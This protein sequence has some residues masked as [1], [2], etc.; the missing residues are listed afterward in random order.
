MNWFRLTCKVLTL[1]LVLDTKA[2]ANSGLYGSYLI[3]VRPVKV[4]MAPGSTDTPTQRLRKSSERS[5]SGLHSYLSREM[6]AS[7]TI[8]T[9]GPGSSISKKVSSYQSFWMAPV[10]KISCRH[11]FLDELR[12]H[13]DV[14]EIV[15][16]EPVY[17][18]VPVVEPVSE[19]VRLPVL[20]AGN[21]YGKGRGIRIGV[22]DSGIVAHPVFGN[23]IRAY[24]DFTSKPLEAMTDTAGHGTFVASLVAGGEYQG[25]SLSFA[26]EADLIVARALETV[27]AGGTSGEVSERVLAFASRILEAMQWILDPDDN[28]STPDHPHIMINSWGFTDRMPIA[29]TF[30]DDAILAW[31]DAGIIVLFAAG[32]E[33]RNGADTIRYPG[34]SSEVLTIG[35]VNHVH[36]VSRFSSLGGASQQKPDFVYYGENRDGLGRFSGRM[37]LGKMSGTSMATPLVGGLIALM[38]EKEP[39]LSQDKIYARL[40]TGALD[41]G[42][43][44][45]DS[46][47]GHGMVQTTGLISQKSDTEGTHLVSELSVC[48][49]KS[50]AE[51]DC[52]AIRSQITRYIAD[53]A[54]AGLWIKIQKFQGEFTLH[55][56]AHADLKLKQSIRQVFNFYS[57]QDSSGAAVS[58]YRSLYSH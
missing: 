47:Y 8:T 46:V 38:L 22:I 51:D 34:S 11:D 20:H 21:G 41:L 57:S 16:D 6:G 23:R 3:R 12:N 13:P 29:M 28:P 5:L 54:E 32:N 18:S 48:L 27:A 10:A 26:P 56:R 53:M 50:V 4:P 9:N 30:F 40:Q 2:M 25:K 49:E 24:R 43:P 52:E 37:E 58:V 39:G 17:L 15:P 31:K 1:V 33:G 42:T 36:Q 44:G 19:D 35:S 55:P 7:E 45:W 14:L